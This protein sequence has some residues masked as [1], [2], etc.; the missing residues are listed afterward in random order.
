MNRRQ[1]IKRNGLWVVGGVLGFPHITRAAHPASGFRQV[2]QVAAGGGGCATTDT[3]LAHDEMLYGWESGDDPAPWT[4]PV[5][6]IDT[7]V[8]S[9]TFD[10]A[11]DTS[12][13]STGKPA[14]ACNVGLRQTLTN[15]A[16]YDT[17]RFDRG[18]IIAVGTAV[19]IRFYIYRQVTVSA[20]RIAILAAGTNTDPTGGLAAV[21][22]M[23][24]DG[25]GTTE[26][27]GDATTSSAWI[28]LTANS[29]N[30]VHLH[31]DATNTSSSIAVNGGAAQTF[32]SSAVSG[33]RYVYVG[34][35]AVGAGISA[36]WVTDLLAV[37]T[38]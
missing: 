12:A 36:Q 16:G 29:W 20:S 7:A 14:G 15:T 32:T 8:D 3:V 30:L 4:G 21:I 26:V 2:R 31:I 22:E 25:G 13:L 28:A 33:V 37:N 17:K 23:R 1:F 19:D 24:D 6:I 34:G 10:T 5:D 27:R 11:Y 35:C 38:P 18:S 9:V